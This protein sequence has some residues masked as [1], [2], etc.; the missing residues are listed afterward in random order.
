MT[1]AREVMDRITDA[2]TH[3]DWDA[4]RSLYAED[5][6]LET[7]DRGT[8]SGREQIVGYFQ[9]FVDALDDV[10]FEVAAKHE[11]GPL[12][13]D[14]GWMSG[15]HSGPM[16]GPDGEM[17]EPTGKRI[18]VRECDLAEVEDGVAR[19]HRMYFDQLEF[20]EQLG[21]AEAAA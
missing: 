14:E 12:A 20:M 1:D 11:I 2:A 18:R 19:R 8:V 17:I 10:R 4:L 15:T 7:P 6:V 13:I 16:P 5:A 21:L 9:R 3:H